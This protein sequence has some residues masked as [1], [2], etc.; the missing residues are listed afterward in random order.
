MEAGKATGKCGFCHA[1]ILADDEAVECSECGTL[2]HRDC[3]N[4]YG[5]CVLPGCT[6][7]DL[8][9]VETATDDDGSAEPATGDRQREGLPKVLVVAGAI[10]AVSFTVVIAAAGVKLLSTSDAPA[11]SASVA[12]VATT[13]VKA[14]RKESADKH[15]VAIR[16]LMVRVHRLIN[17]GDWIN[18]QK[19]L[20]K[21]K[22]SDYSAQGDVAYA[23]QEAMASDDL[24]GTIIPSKLK[25]SRVSVQ[26]RKAEFRL[27]VPRRDGRCYAG[28]TWAVRE[29]GAWRFDP[30][31]AGIPVRRRIGKQ[32]MRNRAA[33]C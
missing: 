1:P 6:G 14:K 19:Y 23:W 17:A 12:P 21:R 16:R 18:S 20:S 15:V 26:G 28:V 33:E 13:K 32:E 30:G 4:D 2:Q 10:L 27:A 8:R 9:Y 22:L 29:N 24:V 31:S 7:H 3:W 11:N 25:V 5:G